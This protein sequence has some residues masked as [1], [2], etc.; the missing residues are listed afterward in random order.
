MHQRLSEMNRRAG[1]YIH[2]KILIDLDGLREDVDVLHQGGK[3]P[4][5]AQTVQ[6]L[7]LGVR[8]LYG[9][10]AAVEF[11][12]LATAFPRWHFSTQGPSPG[13]EDL[14]DRRLDYYE[15]GQ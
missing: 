3:L 8:L 14:L 12:L 6:Y 11:G 13:C 1:A 15:C 10:D 7:I 4:H 2:V 5:I 9:D